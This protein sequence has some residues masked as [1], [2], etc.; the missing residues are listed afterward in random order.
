LSL[1]ICRFAKEGAATLEDKTEFTSFV[2]KL[3]S[4]WTKQSFFSRLK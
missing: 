3:T 4:W 1:G 2:V